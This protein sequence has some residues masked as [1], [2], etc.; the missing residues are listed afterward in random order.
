MRNQP[1]TVF[2]QKFFWDSD[3]QMELANHL[4]IVQE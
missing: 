1:K 2:E 3:W 4:K